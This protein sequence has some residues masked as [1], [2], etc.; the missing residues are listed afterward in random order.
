MAVNLVKAGYPLSI[1]AR[2]PEAAT[3]LT[4]AGAKR[5]S[6]AAELAETSDIVFTMVSD[7][8]D[9][10][11]VITGEQGVGSGAQLG[12]VVV[13]MSTISPAATRKIAAELLA[14]GVHMLDAPVS[15]GEQGAIDGNLSIMVGGKPE[16]FARVRPLFECMG[17]NT[18][19]VG[20]HGAGQVAKACNQVLV[21]QTIAA[22]A[23][24]LLLAKASGA[25]PE[26]V[27][28]ALLGGFAYSRI[29]DLHGQRM[30]DNNYKPGFK[31]KLHLKD[32]RIALNAAREA[33]IDLPG[34]ARTTA[35]LDELIEAGGGELDSAAIARVVWGRE[36]LN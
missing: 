27:R 28:E 8:L 16:V 17:K 15:G 20:D 36:K 33:H 2:K 32:M 29:L 25:N 22:V 6:S 30:L 18:V 21:V 10:E 9:V 4:D 31:S 26:R 7:T 35:N 12:S 19:H 14:S 11:E 23:E 24:A 5:Y 34:A 3:P 1:Y 13:D